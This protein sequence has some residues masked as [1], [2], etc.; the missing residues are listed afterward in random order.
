MS[1]AEHDSAGD[2][3]Q[4]SAPVALQHL[5]ARLRKR[6]EES[7]AQLASPS[8]AR[9]VHIT[10]ECASPTHSVHRCSDAPG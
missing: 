5:R 3:S 2:G 9:A 4:P 10:T 1:F 8:K 7:L 6:L